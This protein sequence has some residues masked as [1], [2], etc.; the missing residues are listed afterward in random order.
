MTSPGLFDPSSHWCI[1]AWM[2]SALVPGGVSERLQSAVLQRRSVNLQTG[3]WN[4]N[5]LGSK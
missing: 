5:T 3:R 2:A 1:E 4:I